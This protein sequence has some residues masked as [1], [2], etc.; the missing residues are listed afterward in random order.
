MAINFRSCQKIF[1]KQV[2]KN[3]QF[4]KILCAFGRNCRTS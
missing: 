4:I 2:F 1:D 3:N